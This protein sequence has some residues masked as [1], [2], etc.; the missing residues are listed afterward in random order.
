MEAIKKKLAALKEEKETAIERAEEAEM[1]KKEVE[2]RLQAVCVCVCVCVCA[3]MHNSFI[4]VSHSPRVS[5]WVW[6]RPVSVN[7]CLLWW[8][9]GRTA[10]FMA[11][12]SLAKREG[13]GKGGRGGRNGGRGKE[14][15]GEKE[16][17]WEGGREGGTEGEKE[18]GREECS[19]WLDRVWG[20][21]SIGIV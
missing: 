21:G 5:E 10:V 17:W 7:Y 19:L 8:I 15:E 11:V 12:Q 1:Q 3:C 6:S 2:A 20:R 16:R 4:T 9:I 14:R 18:E 13:G